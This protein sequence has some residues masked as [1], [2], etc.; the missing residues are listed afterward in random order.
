MDDLARVAEFRNRLVVYLNLAARP[1]GRNAV[2]VSDDT[3]AQIANE[4]AWLN[5]EYGRLHDIIT[6]WGPAQMVV[7]AIGTVSSDVV[8]DAINEA[9]RV[10]YGDI[11][12]YAV[13]HLDIVMG[14]LQAD[15]H[16][17][18]SGSSAH[19]WATSSNSSASLIGSTACVSSRTDRREACLSSRRQAH[20][21]P[22]PSN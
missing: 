3:P 21:A 17:R 10:Y 2:A 9:G 8:R 1:T 7:P 18:R 6:R 20:G 12:R 15:A 16:G 11:A 4:Q 5:R 14:R 13:E 22:S 19:E